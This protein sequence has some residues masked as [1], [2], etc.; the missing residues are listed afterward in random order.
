MPQADLARDPPGV[1]PDP[2]TVRAFFTR[3]CAHATAALTGADQP[4]LLQLSRLHPAEDKGDR[5]GDG[6]LA[7]IGRYKLG[8]VDRLTRDALFY[9]KDGY[10]VFVEGRTIYEGTA[11]NRRGDLKATRLVFAF[12]ID[13]DA[14]KNKGWQATVRPT[15]SVET[16]RGNAQHWLCLDRAMLP[17]EAKA[18]GAAIRT[19]AKA[20]YVTG[21]ITQPYRVPGLP[22]FPNAAKRASGRVAAATGILADDGP[23]WTADRLRTAFPPP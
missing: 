18:L 10:N 2:D 16:S 19:A 11:L 3:L 5:K 9:S 15:L 6:K 20:D 13:S 7:V 21:T 8:E 1:D 14:D 22:N 23:V 4:G 17:D 12:V